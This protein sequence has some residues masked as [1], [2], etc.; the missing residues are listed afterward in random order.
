M[1]NRSDNFA[2]ICA[3]YR[4]WADELRAE[5]IPVTRANLEKCATHTGAN[6]DPMTSRHAAEHVAHCNR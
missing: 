4:V 5:R 3:F 1:H 6:F 2:A